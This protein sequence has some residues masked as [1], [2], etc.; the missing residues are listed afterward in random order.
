MC[1]PHVMQT[2]VFRSFTFHL[3]RE[4]MLFDEIHI[5]GCSSQNTGTKHFFL[6]FILASVKVKHYDR[7]PRTVASFKAALS[8][9]SVWHDCSERE[10]E[11]AMAEAVLSWRSAGADI[12]EFNPARPEAHQMLPEPERSPT[13][14]HS[15]PNEAR[16]IYNTPWLSCQW[17]MF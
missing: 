14:F 11:R 6:S 12:L 9:H 10:R 15:S 8:S 2:P 4:E 7:V 1:A 3:N 5:Y 16:S 17:Y 13:S